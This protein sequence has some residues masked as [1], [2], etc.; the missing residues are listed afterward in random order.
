MDLEKA[1][2]R[3]PGKVLEWAL[4]RKTGI[5]DV[6]VRSVM[7]LYEG[8]RTRV[9]VDF[10][11]SEELEVKEWMHYGSLLSPFLFALSSEGVLCELLYANYLVRML[12]T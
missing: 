4:R 6:L 7:S 2:G 5:S 9:S 8:V 10:E 3:V 1:F 12:M 11:L